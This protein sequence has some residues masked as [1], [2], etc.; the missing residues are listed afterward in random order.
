MMDLSVWKNA[1]LLVE[2]DHI[3][4]SSLKEFL[5]S[6]GYSLLHA[7][8]GIE[9]LEILAACR[10][11]PKLILLDLMMPVLDGWGFLLERRRDARLREIPVVMMTASNG[12]SRKARMAGARA[13][14]HKPFAP[15]DLLPII[16]QFS[17]ALPDC[18]K[19]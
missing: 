9:A 6:E 19:P 12:V 7:E 16:R 15:R 10:F 5:A 18:R 2:D 3:L 14:I 1:L 17:T 13:V 4:G 11:S 8:N